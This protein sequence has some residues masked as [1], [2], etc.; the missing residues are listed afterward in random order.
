MA[1]Y[2]GISRLRSAIT[3]LSEWRA[4]TQSQ[5]SAHLFPFLSLLES[6]VSSDDW[7]RYEEQDDFTFFDKYF[8]VGGNDAK[9]YFDPLGRQRRIETHPHSNVATARKG[10]FENSW[11]AG[12]SKSENGETSWMLAENFDDI[13]RTK[14][15]TRGG[16]TTRANVLDIAA[17]LFRSEEFP[18][19]ADAKSLEDRFKERFPL[20][21]EQYNK[22]FEFNEEPSDNIFTDVPPTQQQI[23]Q[24]VEEL[25]ITKEKTKKTKD[26]GPAEAVHSE[27]EDDDPVLTEVR[28]VLGMGSSG[29]IL[30]GCP[31]TGKSWY[32]W[33]IALD[34][35]DNKPD[36]ITRV[37]FHP[38]YGYED[39]VEGYRPSE[40]KKSGF[41]IVDRTFL[42]AVR[43]AN[44][45]D[46]TIVFI[47]DEINRGDPSRIF[48]EL[49]T[50]VEDGW[51]DVEFTLPY[52]GKILKI[53]K[54]LTVLATM[55]QHDR[56]VTQ[57]DMA[58]LRRF[59]H[60]DILPSKDRVGEF[61]QK[62]GMPAEQATLV[63][64]WFDSMQKL[65]PFGI[66]HTYFLN[67]GDIAR[68]S[69]IW[70]YRI[71]P[72]CESVLEFEEA[73]FNNVKASFEALRKRLLGQN[74]G[75]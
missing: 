60:I 51:R 26:V 3:S 69:T 59:D 37:Q 43:R 41:E 49:L 25:E 46:D 63:V 68:L 18:D 66:G 17:W 23:E 44:G 27:I 20:T 67:V 9:P 30:R 61:L 38:S 33:N 12:A 24:L 35:T 15:M 31:G 7:T 6:G 4:K 34:L 74:A 10:T 58:M 8:R 32:A 47:I 29:I 73:K 62:A 2:I 75:E 14:V 57:L 5:L 11:K 39:F 45:T 72:F 56:S 13:V 22:L 21:E 52:S 28:A 42:D 48:G 50:F 53:P 64:D 70:R 16:E 36:N 54:N 65:M 71:H 19:N 1:H 55:N 40:E